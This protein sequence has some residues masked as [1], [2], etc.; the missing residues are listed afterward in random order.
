MKKWIIAAYSGEEFL[1]GF[2]EL[3]SY[4]PQGWELFLLTK[5]HAEK[6]KIYDRPITLI[7]VMPYYD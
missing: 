5:K 7:K 3:Y 2:I 4:E 1:F 6:L